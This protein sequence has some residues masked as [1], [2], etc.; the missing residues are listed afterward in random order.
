MEPA[1]NEFAGTVD[2]GA[3]EVASDDRIVTPSQ[4]HVDMEIDFPVLGGD[5]ADQA[6]DF[7]LLVES[8]VHVALGLRVQKPEG[9]GIDGAQA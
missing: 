6:G 4:V 5:V 9:C 1:D 2:A 7:H 3:E 8:L